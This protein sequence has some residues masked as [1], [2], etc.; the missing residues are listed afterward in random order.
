MALKFD[1]IEIVVAEMERSLAFYREL[2]L[3]IPTGAGEDG[4]P[5][6]E[7]TL[8][9]GLRIAWDTAELIRQMDAGWTEPAGG[10][11]V[12]LA[13]AC[14]STAD[15]D[16]TYARLTGLGYDGHMEPWD[17]FWGQR[18]AV[19]HDPDGNPVDLFCSLPPTQ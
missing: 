9:G 19:V 11:R 16:E 4:S 3:A 8:P 17:A 5:H 6:A 2:G 15:V 13:F 18:Y 7:T 1:V 14:E 10:H 12:A